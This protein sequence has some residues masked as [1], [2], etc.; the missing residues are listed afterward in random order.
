MRILRNSVPKQIANDLEQ[1]IKNGIYLVGDKL[2][3]EP[4]LVEIYQASRNTVREAVQSLI[5]ANLLQA[6]QGSGTYVIAKERLQ[7]EFFNLMNDIK[8]SDVIEVRTF[9]ESYIVESAIINHTTEDIKNI[10]THLQK[11]NQL[12]DAIKENTLA[13]IE[14]HKAIAL[15]THNPLL[16]KS[17][18]Y[19]SDFFYEFI[20]HSVK[21]N[22]QNQDKINILHSDLVTAIKEKNTEKAKKITNEIINI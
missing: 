1:K 18:E 20:S 17:Y 21:A 4:E 15:S 5:H 11:R 22:V 19:I 8:K 9:L 6:K 16:Y 13:D 3:T 10:E 2:P 7:V 14:F 12:F